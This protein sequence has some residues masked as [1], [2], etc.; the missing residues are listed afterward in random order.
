MTRL[1]WAPVN[2][3]L[4]ASATAKWQIS[5]R[6]D[7]KLRDY[8]VQDHAMHGKLLIQQLS[9]HT[10]FWGPLGCLLKNY[11]SFFMSFKM[12]YVAAKSR[13]KGKKARG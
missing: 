10:A 3:R 13:N 8:E 6:R 9:P 7:L 12:S 2:H 5:L 1:T 4:P 11:C